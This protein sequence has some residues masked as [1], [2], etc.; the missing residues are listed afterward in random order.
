[1]THEQ[2]LAIAIVATHLAEENIPGE[3]WEEI[4]YDELRDTPYRST[5]KEIR[6]GL[7]LFHKT[8]RSLSERMQRLDSYQ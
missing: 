4:I 8:W 2:K 3:D 1:M 7:E 5:N 6:F